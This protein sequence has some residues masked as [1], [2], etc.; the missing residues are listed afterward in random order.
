M[1]G[2]CKRD[3]EMGY[4]QSLRVPPTQHFLIAKGKGVTPQWR[5]LEDPRGAALIKRSK[6]VSPGPGAVRCDGSPEAPPLRLSSQRHNDSQEAL[7]G[8]LLGHQDTSCKEEP[9]AQV[10]L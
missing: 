2:Y 6:S 9:C 8:A 5:P 10:F 1:N 3:E 7:T 4:L